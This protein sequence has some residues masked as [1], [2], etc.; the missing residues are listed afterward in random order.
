MLT[1][2]FSVVY[3][4]LLLYYDW[5]LALIALGISLLSV[6]FTLGLGY[7]YIRYQKP[8]NEIEGKL[9]GLILQL[10]TG[11]SKLRIS[12]TE[13]RGF[14]VWAQEFGE[15]RRFSLKSRK[16]QNVLA[17]VNAVIPVCASML[18]Y[19]FVLSK[20]LDPDKKGLST[21]DLLA[22]LSA[23]GTFQGNLL[24]MSGSMLNTLSVIPFYERLK[25]ILNELPEVDATKSHPGVLNGNIEVTQVHFRYKADGP[26]ILHN[27]SLNISGGEFVALVGGSGSGK[28]TLMRLLLGFESAESGTIYFDG[29]DLSK[30]DVLEV[31]RQIG[32][33]LQMRKLCRARFIKILSV[34]GLPDSQLAMPGGPLGWQ[35]VIV[36][37]GPC[38]WGCILC[39]RREEAPFQGASGNGLSLRGRLSENL[40]FCFLTKQ[41]VRWITKPRQLS[42]QASK[43]STP[44][45]LLLLTD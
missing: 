8:L 2:I 28:S 37:F 40:V 9:S 19:Y 21:G 34:Q 39:C 22:F 25:P 16:V 13:D 30:V 1:V 15:Q 23:Y 7:L 36:I 12:G 31:R 5:F 43:N 14:A 11:I 10:I 42:V 4:G 3:L 41:R 32:V 27:V 24:Q 18:F 26:L 6:L 20:I 35:A 45:V 29:Q 38:R 44:P 33:V 17:T